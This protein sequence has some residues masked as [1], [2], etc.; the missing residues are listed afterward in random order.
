MCR[1]M[2]EFIKNNQS[3]IETYSENRT[4]FV[5][6]PNRIYRILCSAFYAFSCERVGIFK[7]IIDH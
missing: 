4:K 5:A 1:L 7:I 6:L 3:Y 2:I